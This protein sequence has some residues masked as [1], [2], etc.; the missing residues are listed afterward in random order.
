MTQQMLLVKASD[1]CHKSVSLFLKV[2]FATIVTLSVDFLSGK[3]IFTPH[4]IRRR[5]RKQELRSGKGFCVI[6]P[7]PNFRHVTHW[8]ME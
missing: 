1:L 5:R 8:K 4:W 3:A 2:S 7:R 6:L